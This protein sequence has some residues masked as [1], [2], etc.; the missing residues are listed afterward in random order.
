MDGQIER[1]TG[2]RPPGRTGRLLD[3]LAQVAH[4]VDGD[5][6]LDVERLADAGVDDR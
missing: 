3:D 6:H 2:R 5:D 1:R 4:V